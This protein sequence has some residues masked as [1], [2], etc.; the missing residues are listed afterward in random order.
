[1]RL[2]AYN[3]LKYNRYTITILKDTNPAS[4]ERKQAVN[5]H[6]N[7]VDWVKL[8]EKDFNEMVEL[9]I[10]LF[11]SEEATLLSTLP[12]WRCPSC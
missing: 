2:T 6:C 3:K 7:E 1:M 8:C 11:Y 9:I 10:F 4:L 5:K 12:V